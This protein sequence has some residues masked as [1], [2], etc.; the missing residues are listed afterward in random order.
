M[1]SIP[2]N[3][4]FNSVETT[5]KTKA[6]NVFSTHPPNPFLGQ[7]KWF[8]S[9]KKYSFF[10]ASDTLFE[11]DCLNEISNFIETEMKEFKKSKDKVGNSMNDKSKLQDEDRSGKYLLEED[12]EDNHTHTVDLDKEGNGTSSDTSEH[13]HKIT[14]WK[15]E[16]VNNHIHGLKKVEEEEEPEES[17][18]LSTV[19]LDS[20][21]RSTRILQSSAISA[22]LEEHKPDGD[23]KA[24]ASFRKREGDNSR[25]WHFD[26]LIF[27]DELTSELV[28]DL[29]WSGEF[30]FFEVHPDFANAVGNAIIDELP[31]GGVGYKVEHKTEATQLSDD[32]KKALTAVAP[33]E[34]PKAPE[35]TAWDATAAIDR[36]KKWASSDESGDKEKVDWAKF[37]QAFTYVD[38]DNADDF[39]GYKLPHHD[40]IDGFKVVWKGVA[41]AM[42]ALL[43]ARGG[44]DIPEADMEG[45][46]NHLKRH[47]GQFDKEAPE[48]SEDEGEVLN[49]NAPYSMPK[50]TLITLS[51]EDA[52]RTGVTKVLVVSGTLLAEGDWK[53]A[54]YSEKVINDSLPRATNL[55]IDIEHADET[56]E[57]VKGF[58]YKP[59]WNGELKGIDVGGIIFDERVVEWA[60]A[61]PDARIGISA[62]LSK[63]TKYEMVD[64][65][66]NCTYLGYKGMALTLAPA[67]K[68]CWLTSM[69][70]V[71][72]SSNTLSDV[73]GI[74]MAEEQPK[75]TPPGESEEV[76][77]PV[78]QTDEAGKPPEFKHIIKRRKR[79]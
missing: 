41:A 34:T 75:V 6:W 23:M 62:K 64:G 72:L 73:G 38:P 13:S 63:D 68:V 55:R 78:V 50:P 29:L 27:V 20:N 11:V 5:G 46:Y 74:E 21:V 54:G 56:W 1:V 15:V 26:E 7:I 9:W 40:I 42:G 60:E 24:W 61:N 77:K 30:R 66:K 76:V 51:D 65:K 70:V 71:E 59:R 35:E 3:L 31:E 57:D 28:A 48:L 43:G 53:G 14:L 44:V 22:L 12:G 17:E 58:N 36:L 47:Y 19:A 79:K 2:H 49:E 33:H 16:R 10:P 69:K 67:C 37:K 32:E 52:E 4:K 45:V 39:G 18:E 25:G 8:S